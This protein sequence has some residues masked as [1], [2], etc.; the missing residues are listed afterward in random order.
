M[1]L[2]LGKLTKGNELIRMLHIEK[3]C[4]YVSEYAILTILISSHGVQG[5]WLVGDVMALLGRKI[6]IL[7]IRMLGVRQRSLGWDYTLWVVRIT[8]SRSY[9]EGGILTH[10]ESEKER[11]R[12]IARDRER[13]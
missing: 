8:S 10:S 7:A 11:E 4:L 13:F 2:F 9:E 12:E 5:V 6:L 3:V 1:H